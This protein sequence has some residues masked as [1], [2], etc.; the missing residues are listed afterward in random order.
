MEAEA[1]AKLRG[2]VGGVTGILQIAEK[3]TLGTITREAGLSILEIIFGLSTEDA[4]KLLGEVEE[5]K[6]LADGNE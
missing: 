6:E 2:S 1:K 3:V 5:K 4:I